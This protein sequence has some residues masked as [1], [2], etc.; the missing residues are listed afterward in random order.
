MNSPT[1]RQEWS[2]KW[3]LPFV[4]MFGIAGV[5]MFP[6]SSGVFMQAVTGTFGWSR[7]QF[8]AAFL[9]QVLAGLVAIPLA[10]QLADRV[11]A[12]KVVLWGIVPFAASLALLG[13]ATGSIWQ[14]WALCLL[15][16]LFV[17]FVSPPI[18]IKPVVAQFDVSRGLALSVAL[19]GVGL[20]T[21]IWPLLA[22]LYIGEFGWR[23]AYFLIA[24]T[25]AVPM[26]ILAYF[27]FD[28]S[29]RRVPPPQIV[30]QRAVLRP[31]LVSPTFLYLCGAG[32]LYSCM[33]YGLFIQLVPIMQG[34]GLSLAMAATIVGIFGSSSI[35][36]RLLIGYL[37]DRLPTR[38]LSVAVFLLPVPATLLLWQSSG[39]VPM[40]IAAAAVF[41][42]AG[43]G[44]T[45]ILA[46]LAAKRFPKAAFA[47]IYGVATAVFALTASLGPLLAAALFDAWQSYV[48]FLL[49]IIPMVCVGALLIWLVPSHSVADRAGASA[50]AEVP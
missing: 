12:R 8:A 33:S 35:V 11:G 36:G 30:A 10:G 41:G 17:G 50:R 39:S 15:N 44:E 25:W 32:G 23:S 2:S 29:S 38:M 34:N 18:W 5:T 22:A 42:L 19:G 14:W 4:A 37:L 27:L 13:L 47:S 7:S 6:T 26:A 20:S 9:I 24:A 31:Y 3:P 1:V 49:M 48:P 43:G 21:M 46:Y 16:A 40:A 45:D 28:R